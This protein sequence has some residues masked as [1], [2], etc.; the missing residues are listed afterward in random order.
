MVFGIG[1]LLCLTIVLCCILLLLFGGCAW[2]FWF[3]D[4][5]ELSKKARLGCWWSTFS[6]VL[7]F[8]MRKWQTGVLLML[9]SPV[10][11][12]SYVC[13]WTVYA[14]FA[15][16]SY[17]ELTYKNHSD[18]VALTRLPEIPNISYSHNM[19][20]ASYDDETTSYFLFEEHLSAE[21]IH[22]MEALLSTKIH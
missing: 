6:F 18:M 17:D 4:K 5:K 14:M 12:C 7:P 22:K 1:I 15:P 3:Y 11:L 8:K 2:F 16:V 19:H 13:I 10:A 21:S 20:D 9:V